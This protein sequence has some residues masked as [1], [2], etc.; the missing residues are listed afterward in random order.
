MTVTLQDVVV[1]T[2]SGKGQE[3]CENDECSAASD[4]ACFDSVL[5]QGLDSVD[6]L[7]VTQTP[8]CVDEEGCHR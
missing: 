2:S 6:G 8:P 7:G 4:E 3:E 1:S 5:D